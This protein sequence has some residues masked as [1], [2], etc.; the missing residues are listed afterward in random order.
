MTIHMTAIYSLLVCILGL[1]N[2]SSRR[3]VD[4]FPTIRKVMLGVICLFA[5]ITLAVVTVSIRSK[6]LLIHRPDGLAIATSVLTLV[7]L[8][9]C[10]MVF[11]R[12]DWAGMELNRVE[13]TSAALLG[14][15]WLCVGADAV[16]VKYKSFPPNCASINPELAFDDC[17]ALGAIAAL[18]FMIT[19]MLIAYFCVDT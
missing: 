16:A 5:F 10:L 19:I 13:L 15:L 4:L 11:R 1:V 3:I 2:K 9:T 6:I 14:V 12:G 8:P 18:G 17:I 7:G